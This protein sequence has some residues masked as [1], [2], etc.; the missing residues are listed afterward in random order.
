LTRSVG[1]SFAV[2]LSTL[3]GTGDDKDVLRLGQRM[4][5]GV[6]ILGANLRRSTI[7]DST[8]STGRF[9]DTAMISGFPEGAQ[10]EAH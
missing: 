10:C 9:F 5:R 6:T 3:A 1:C 8:R 4:A 2:G 7:W